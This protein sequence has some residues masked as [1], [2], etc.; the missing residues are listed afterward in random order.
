MREGTEKVER[1]I[2]IVD[3]EGKAVGSTTLSPDVFGVEPHQHALYEA[4]KV[5]L[6]NRRQ[7]TAS[8]KGRSEVRG[9]GAK[10]W[11]QKGTGRAR[12]GTNRSPLWKGGG[13]V[14][15]PKPRTYRFALHK[16]MNTLARKSALSLKARESNIVVVEELA[17]DAPKTKQMALFLHKLDLHQKKVL[18]LTV[19]ADEN[20]LKSCRNISNLTVKRARDVAAYELLNCETVLLTKSALEQIEEVLGS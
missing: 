16:K 9:G 8:T 13:I 6:G 20:L 17:F 12:A 11:R 4:V 18:F 5:F 10:P 15:G 1:T 19:D 14:F 7:G 2:S 3:G